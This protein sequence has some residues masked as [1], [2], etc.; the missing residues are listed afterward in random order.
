MRSRGR[1]PD[2]V[3]RASF[4]EADYTA[5]LRTR[6]PVSPGGRLRTPQT[7]RHLDLGPPASGAARTVL[8]V[9]QPPDLRGAVVTRPE[10]GQPGRTASCFMGHLQLYCSPTHSRNVFEVIDELR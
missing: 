6:L 7:C 1:S 9:A 3:R 5:G 2:L 4:E 10:L 8:S